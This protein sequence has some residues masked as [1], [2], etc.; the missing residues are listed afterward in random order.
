VA[1]IAGFDTSIDTARAQSSLT[2]T[3]DLFPGLEG[4]KNP[5]FW[6]GLRPMTPDNAPIISATKL[7]KLYINTGHGVLGWTMSCG[8]SQIIADIITN[9]QPSIS[10]EG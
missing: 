10:L 2:T 8:S 5:E 1:E 7:K 6:T 3:I 9:K 4:S